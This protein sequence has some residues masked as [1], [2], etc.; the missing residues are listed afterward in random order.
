MTIS[1]STY[2]SFRG[3]PRVC[4]DDP[5]ADRGSGG[6]RA[7]C[8]HSI[9]EDDVA[10]RP[11]R[12]PQRRPFGPA[13]CRQ[14]IV[15]R[16]VSNGATGSHGVCSPFRAPD[17]HGHRSRPHQSV[18]RVDGGSRG[19]RTTRGRPRIARITSTSPPRRPCLCS[20]GSRPIEC[21]NPRPAHRPEQAR[22]SARGRQK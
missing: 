11:G 13:S 8:E 15:S 19:A 22:S 4:L 18:R 21:G 12:H 20:F 6:A 3:D 17:V 5:G 2:A 9:Y 7:G 14:R 1:T 10:E 16:R